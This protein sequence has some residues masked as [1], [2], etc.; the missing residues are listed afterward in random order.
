MEAAPVVERPKKE[1]TI[2]PG[3]GTLIGDIE[4]GKLKVYVQFF[5]HASKY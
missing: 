4:N 2:E 5:Q 1:L 3:S